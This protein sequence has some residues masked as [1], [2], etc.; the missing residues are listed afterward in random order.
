M[1][2]E[3]VADEE[4]ATNMLHTDGQEPSEFDYIRE[5]WPYGREESNPDD[6][7]RSNRFMSGY[8]GCTNMDFGEEDRFGNGCSDY[9][10]DAYCGK[11][12]TLNFASEEVCCTCGGGCFDDAGG[13][14]GSNNYGCEYYN[15]LPNKCGEFDTEEFISSEVCC[16]CMVFSE[17]AVKREE[18]DDLGTFEEVEAALD[19]LNHYYS[20]DLNSI[21]ENDVFQTGGSGV[22]NAEAG[23]VFGLVFT[24]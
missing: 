22:V 8:T 11:F 20:Y 2:G 17:W 24:T 12:D 21:E 18:F 3:D 9:I 4:G 10:G 23:Q 19:E 14:L 15:A 1:D 6:T 13:H 16:A 5:V 7:E